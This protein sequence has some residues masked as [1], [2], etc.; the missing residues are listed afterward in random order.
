ML[1][2][3]SAVISTW[4]AWV[5]L[6]GGLICLVV[7]LRAR[8]TVGELIAPVGAMG[9]VGSVTHF[10]WGTAPDAALIVFDVIAMVV[11]TAWFV[12]VYRA[13]RERVRLLR[14]KQ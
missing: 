2:I 11:L 9:I 3:D 10:L 1:P 12:H 13:S 7:G 5:Q 4:L 8:G 6:V 14:N